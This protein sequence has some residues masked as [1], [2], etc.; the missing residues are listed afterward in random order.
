MNQLRPIV[1]G[2]IFL[3]FASP[4]TALVTSSSFLEEATEAMNA[5]G[6]DKD[7]DLPTWRIGDEWVYDTKFDVAQ[8]IAQANVSASLNTLT[9]ETTYTVTDILFTTVDGI[10]TLA[11]K[12]EIDGD[13]TSGNSGATL[14]G[15]SGRL[16][17]GYQGEDL[18][19]VRDLAVINSDFTLD[20]KFRP[21]NLGFLEQD[22][23]EITFDTIYLPPKEKYDF[24]IH[25]GDQWYMN[26]MSGTSVSGSSEYFDPSA[27][28]TAGP[29]N[30]SWQITANGPPTDG[31]N[32]IDYSGCADS[33]KINEVNVTGVS[34]GYNWYC[35]AVRY[36]SWM[37]VSNA[38]GFTID[39]L[40]K[41]Y[42][43][44]DSY[45]VSSSSTPGTRN[46][47]IDVDMQFLATLPDTEQTVTATY[48]T[49]PN[50]VPQANKNL[51]L[52]Y[53]LDSHLANP[54]TDGSGV[55]TS[56]LNVSNVVD[57]TPSSDDFTSNGVIVWDP[58]TE[59]IGAATVVIDLTV[60]GIDLVAQADSIIVTRTRDGEASILS[61]VTGYAALP[62][63]LI[64]FSIP[65]QNRGVLTSPATEIEVITPDGTSIRQNI[66]PISSYSEERIT[67]NWTVPA[68]TPVGNQTLSFTVDP[69]QL[70][71][72][73]ANR[74]NND[75]EINIFIGRAPTGSLVVDMNKLTFENV[76]LNA[77]QSF[78]E[79]GGDVNCKFEIESRPGLI[80]VIES[81]DCWTQ[82]NWSDDGEWSIRLIITDE[83]LDTD[84]IHYNVTVLNRN[85]YLNL[86]VVPS[87]DVEEKVTIDA[88]DSGDVDTVSPS[89]QQVSIS[90]PGMACEEGLTQP[91]CTITPMAEGIMM[92]TAVATD[93]DGAT[94]T[95]ETPL[96]VLNVAPTLA[97]P[98]LWYGG[99]NLSV[100]SLGVWNLD[101]DQVALLRI[102]ADDTL[103]DRDDINIEW[104]PSDRNL[105]WTETTRGPASTATVAWITSGIH[106]I[107]VVAYDDDGERSIVQTGSV[108]IR[109]VAPT[110]TGLGSDVPILEDANVTFTAIVDDTASDL[111][112][113]V[114]CWDM[115]AAIDSD[116][117]G[118]ALNDCEMEGTEITA[119][120]ST[121]GIRQIT[122]TVTDDDGAQALTSVN[123][124]VQN[125]PPSAT[126]TN[127]TSVIELME[128]ENITL[129]GLTSRETAGDKLTLLYQWDSDHYDSD[130]DQI[131]TG[132]VD[133]SGPMYTIEDLPPGQ[134]IVVLTVTDDDG[135]FSTASIQLTVTERP[136]EGFIES[137]SGAIGTVPGA[138]IG[139]LGIIVV[140]LAGFLL[141]TRGKNNREE[142]NFSSFA[143]MPSGEPPAPVINSTA[144]V[145]APDYAA[146]ADIYGQTGYGQQPTPAGAADQMYAPTQAF[147]A[148]PRPKYD[149]F[150]AIAPAP[151]APA[152]APAPAAV[153]Q[154]IAPAPVQSGPPLPVT[155]LPEGW[156]MEQWSHYGAQYLA[157]QQGQPT[158][159]QPASTD[160]PAASPVSDMTG[161]LDDLDL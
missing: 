63:D 17:I 83:E 19:R 87:I 143:A 69:D 161:L 100:D 12:L 56:Q 139:S 14:E 158:A 13:F 68:Q 81:Q 73:D 35:P 135:E 64:T 129:S 6:W 31:A 24:P 51:Q 131:K 148:V 57:S 43:P 149:P 126:I 117:D 22:I 86:S 27:F 128:G 42:N 52:R 79:D 146:Q 66:P 11:Y 25:L 140:L 18:V 145:A 94:T 38:A 78:D 23:A 114:V 125:L 134:W 102:N 155:G 116:S 54:T 147:A 124:S 46:V 112:T 36:N 71:T 75:A 132:D 15:V 121:R 111:D 90:W 9:G 115:N 32:S 103:S 159:I 60:V 154:Q 91:T 70:V 65:A 2:L 110:I 150:A 142:E 76:T 98:E 10:Q 45:G 85:P 101:E 59:I 29:E 113:L 50:N 92:I 152:P 61:K 104:T 40:L 62:G 8:L 37:R 72:E 88:T 55:I 16:N 1:L 157:A 39:W 151:V 53:E 74:S 47:E 89:G 5:E 109:N 107:S 4:F 30:A 137:V 119:M 108:N 106:N 41:E 136:A 33:Y 96:D 77:T 133:F 49:S 44:T 95:V 84:I 82:W 99:S 160:T 153:V 28:D 118:N 67:V 141:L 144:P 127:S 26:F 58:A 93:D 20:V 120:W 122:A 138:I 97:A 7:K 156:S 21:F 80:D 34:A 130:L 105:N 48:L 123:V 3:M